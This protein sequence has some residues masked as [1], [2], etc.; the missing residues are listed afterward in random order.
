MLDAL[1]HIAFGLFGLAMLIGIAWLFSNNKRA[2]DWKLVG[3]GVALLVPDP[4]PSWPTPF[5]PQHHTVSSSR[6]A[7]LKPRPAAMRMELP[8]L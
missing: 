3:T 1:G 6:R 5:S 8:A 2:V 4:S 7:Q